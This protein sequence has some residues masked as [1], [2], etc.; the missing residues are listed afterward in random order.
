M[1]ITGGGGQG[2]HGIGACPPGGPNLVV[3]VAAHHFVTV[4]GSGDSAVVSARRPDGVVID[5]FLVDLSLRP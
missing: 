1:V 4:E 3:G 5:R 2:L